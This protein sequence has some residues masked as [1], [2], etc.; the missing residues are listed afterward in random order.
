MLSHLDGD[1]APALA[2]FGHATRLANLLSPRL[3]TSAT[4][5]KTKTKTNTN[6]NTNTKETS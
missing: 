2:L 6:T 1:R 3:D 5:T 4:K